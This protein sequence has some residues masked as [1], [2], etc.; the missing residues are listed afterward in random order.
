MAMSQGLTRGFQCAWAER[1]GFSTV[2]GGD[3]ALADLRDPGLA[4][5]EAGAGSVESI[6]DNSGLLMGCY[7]LDDDGPRKNGAKL[8]RNCHG[9]NSGAETIVLTNK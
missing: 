1:S 3:S 6:A 9:R 7:D 2:A 8:S 4:E 5:P